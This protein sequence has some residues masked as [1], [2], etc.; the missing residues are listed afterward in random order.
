MI[1]TW[2]L[3][4][5]CAAL[6]ATAISLARVPRQAAAQ[7]QT[8]TLYV[9]GLHIG[10]KTRA[11]VRLTNTS[12]NAADAFALHYTVQ[13][14]NA[15]ESLSLPGAG[16]SGAP[17][18]NGHTLE[19]DLGAIVNAYRASRDAGPFT[20]PVR[21]VAF[22]DDGAYLPFGPETV[23]VTAVQTEGAAR[24]EPLVQWR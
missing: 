16:V 1:R 11:V 12:P 7:E 21:L 14:A 20:G 6:G 22:A 13:A 4:G 9:T 15:G 24:F 19:L 10:G 8:R 17:I 2:V 3:V 23:H 5:L 18:Y